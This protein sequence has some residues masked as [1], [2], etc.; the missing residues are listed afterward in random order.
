[1]HKF[2][3]Q[4]RP[5]I[6]LC[7]IVLAIVVMCTGCYGFVHYSPEED[8]ILKVFA[9]WSWKSLRVWLGSPKQ[10]PFHQFL[11]V[12]TWIILYVLIYRVVCN[13]WTIISYPW[14]VV[15]LIKANK[16]AV[17]K[18]TNLD[19][20]A[21]LLFGTVPPGY[22]IYLFERRPTRIEDEDLHHPPP[23][24]HE[25]SG[26]SEVT[27]RWQHPSQYNTEKYFQVIAPNID[28]AII[29]A[30]KYVKSGRRD[31]AH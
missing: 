18:E 22:L 4:Y 6:L 15:R 19:L 14:K 10:D 26:I 23:Y 17:V 24:N 29:K 21:E 16:A 3:E 31:N 28:L 9:E 25:D 7:L 5:I 2:W 20:E 12:I 11:Q 1:M 8:S 30:N 13:L 27:D